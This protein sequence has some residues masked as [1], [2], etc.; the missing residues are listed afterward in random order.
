MKKAKPF[1]PE[2]EQIEI[3][4]IDGC[5]LRAELSLQTGKPVG[6]AVLAHALMTSRSEFSPAQDGG[7]ARFLTERGWRVV[8]FDF[9]GHGDSGV[10]GGGRPSPGYDDLVARD[11]PAVC[12]FARSQSGRQGPVIVV[13]H[14]LGGHVALAAQ[15]TGAIRVDAIVALGAA[16]WLSGL[17]PSLARWAVKRAMLAAAMAVSR[18]VGRFP[19]RAL[20]LGSD[21]VPGWLLEDLERYARSGKWTSSDGGIDYL[22]ALASVQ[23]PVLHVTSEGDRFECV[24]ECGERF[25]A[26]CGRQTQTLR[27]GRADVDDLPPSHMGLVTSS[28]ARGA[29]DQVEAWM[30]GCAVAR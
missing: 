11:M 10:D 23:I 17:E 9:R 22:A 12:D 29:W 25:A 4:S 18:R 3:R 5:S 1:E 13:G 21:D 28:S 8:A 26:R 15:A 6:V 14:S 30:R 20:H 16:V 2:V 19:A 7:F 24:P 27:I